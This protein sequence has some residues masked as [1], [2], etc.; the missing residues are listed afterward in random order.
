MGQAHAGR[1][2]PPVPP[3][4]GHDP[5]RPDPRIGRLYAPRPLAVGDRRFAW[6]REGSCPPRSTG[7]TLSPHAQLVGAKSALDAS[8]V[9][10][11]AGRSRHFSNDRHATSLAVNPNDLVS[12]WHS[13]QHAGWP[14]F[15]SPN[16]GALMTL[17][18]VISG[19]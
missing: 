5:R 14:R 19:C 4:S 7:F 9:R 3:D 6:S 17:D 2:F 15:S 11:D 12:L 16:E 10:A 13:H 18:T 8:A 1:S